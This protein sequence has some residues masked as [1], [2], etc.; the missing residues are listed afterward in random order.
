MVEVVNRLIEKFKNRNLDILYVVNEWSHPIMR[1]LTRNAAAKGTPGAAL[2]SRLKRANNLV[3]SKS[4][5]SAFTNHSFGDFLKSADIKHLYISGLAAEYCV[6][7]TVFAALKRKYSVT[8][9]S[10]AVAAQRCH[11]LLSSLDKYRAKGAEVISSES[12]RDI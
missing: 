11:K 2:D 6:K 7:A 1:L 8:V 5:P 4:K 9:F 12:F 10:D 3:F